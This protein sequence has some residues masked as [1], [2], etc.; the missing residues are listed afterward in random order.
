MSNSKDRVTCKIDL[1]CKSVIKK[2]FTS[3][4]GT[5]FIMLAFLMPLFMMI[6]GMITDIGRALVFKS[7]LNRACMIASEEASKQINMDLAE[8]GGEN[9]LDADYGQVVVEYFTENIYLRE[10]HRIKS[11][12]Y[13]VLEGISNPRYLRVNAVANIDCFFLKIIGINSI[14]IHSSACGRLKS[15]EG[16]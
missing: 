11:L 3:Q 1:P 10:C 9:I 13:G 14:D 16:V 2:A 15:L 12:E 5:V 7:E 6:T 8:S 4:T